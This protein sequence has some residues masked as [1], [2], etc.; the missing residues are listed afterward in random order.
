ML[1]SYELACKIALPMQ[2]MEVACKPKSANTLSSSKLSH[3]YKSYDFC[4]LYTFFFTEWK[5]LSTL[6]YCKP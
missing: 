2:Y 3:K 4:F 6:K 5:N 1:K